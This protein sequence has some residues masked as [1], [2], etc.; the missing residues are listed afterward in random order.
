[1]LEALEWHLLD[2]ELEEFARE[3]AAIQPRRRIGF[4][5]GGLAG[6][7]FIGIALS[8][9]RRSPGKL[10]RSRLRCN[11]RGL[12]NQHA[13]ERA[14]IRDGIVIVPIEDVALAVLEEL[15]DF[16]WNIRKSSLRC[17]A[18]RRCEK[19]RRGTSVSI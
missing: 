3:T 14:G 10:S 4:D 6:T 16:R 18:I 9:P 19:S 11:A 13:V 8:K 15:G 2:L 7:T 17:A 5:E 1:L 12:R